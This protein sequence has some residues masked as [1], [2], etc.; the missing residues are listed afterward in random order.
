MF[1][2]MS[3]LKRLWL[4]VATLIL[5]PLHTQ[6]ANAPDFTLAGL[7]TSVKLS[8]HRGEVVYLD[9]WASWCAPCRKSFPWMNELQAKFSS[10]GVTVIAI[11]LDAKRAD[12]LTFLKRN[13][14]EFT[15]AF[16]ATGGSAQDWQ[17]RGMPSSYIIDR[18]GNIAYAHIGF[19]A[20]D[21]HIIEAKIAELIS[22][23]STP[24]VLVSDLQEE[25]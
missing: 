16:D 15:V 19:R 22:A 4:L 8:E 21:K 9:F 17:V 3:E 13:P 5:L 12:A 25:L 2:P 1:R 14:A 20:K 6:A 24:K 23:D 11:N 10:Q 18:D 7:D